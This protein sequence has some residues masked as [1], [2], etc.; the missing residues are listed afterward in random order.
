MKTRDFIKILQEADPSGDLHVRIRSSGEPTGAGAVA[1]YWDG[2]FHYTEKDK[3]II[4]DK[5]P[6]LDIFCQEID[7]F[8]WD[9]EGCIDNITID[10]QHGLLGEDRAKALREHIQQTSKEAK[11]CIDKIMAD[12]LSKV[13]SNMANGWKIVQSSN[14][15]IK[16]CHKQWYVKNLDKFVDYPSGE[17]RKDTDNQKKLCQGECQAVLYSGLFTNH[18]DGKLIH[19][20]LKI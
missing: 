13:Q 4:T 16:L 11:D 2:C 15:D 9:E 3:L 10:I 18:I 12:M 7:D 14:Y 19:W 5:I 6:K 17:E 8:I 20:K 1:G